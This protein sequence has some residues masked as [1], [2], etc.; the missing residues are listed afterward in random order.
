MDTETRKVLDTLA[1][2][3]D[4]KDREANQLVTARESAVRFQYELRAFIEG[5]QKRKVSDTDI[6]IAV[7]TKL[8]AV[9][10]HGR[11][12]EIDK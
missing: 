4:R 5:E 2:L 3:I 6:I 8:K 7:L 9:T 12:N 10:P 11:F 1:D